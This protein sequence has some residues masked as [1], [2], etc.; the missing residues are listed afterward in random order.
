MAADSTK[1]DSTKAAPAVAAPMQRTSAKPA[2]TT[3]VG[4]TN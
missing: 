1:T 2:P 4:G 3:S